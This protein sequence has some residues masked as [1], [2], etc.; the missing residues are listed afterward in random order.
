MVTWE[1]VLVLLF[2]KNKQKKNIEVNQSR[3][4]FTTRVHADNIN[5]Q[6]AGNIP[7]TDTLTSTFTQ[8]QKLVYKL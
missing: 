3:T 4:R 7:P 2:K 5:H 1:V 6:S 8:V